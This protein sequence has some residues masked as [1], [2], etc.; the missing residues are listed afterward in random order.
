ML[1][2]GQEKTD[3]R[4][5]SRTDKLIPVHPPYNFVVRG[6]NNRIF[7]QIINNPLENTCTIMCQGYAG[8]LQ[9]QRNYEVTGENNTLLERMPY[10]FAIL[11]T[12]IKVTYE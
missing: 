12:K 2:G 10:N 5:D 8:T 9:V 11:S 4:P 1:L 6:Y 7:C 3:G